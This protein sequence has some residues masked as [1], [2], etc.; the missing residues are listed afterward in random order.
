VAAASWFVAAIE[1]TEGRPQ[2][3]TIVIIE[4][5]RHRRVEAMVIVGS[6]STAAR[7]AD[8]RLS[9]AVTSVRIAIAPVTGE[10]RGTHPDGDRPKQI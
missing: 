7:I 4:F 6:C 10:M 9:G 8:W 2:P 3:K 1:L 5:S